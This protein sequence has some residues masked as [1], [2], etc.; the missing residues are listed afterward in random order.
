MIGGLMKT[1]SRFA[2]AAAAGLFAG[3][4]ALSPANAADLGGDCCADLEERVAELEATTVRKGNRK[5]SLNLSGHVNK[6]IM[7]WDD[8]INNDVY[9][10]DNDESETR[11]RLT[12]AAS[13]APGW[14]AGFIIE[15]EVESASSDTVDQRFDGRQRENDDGIVNNRRASFHVKNDQLGK[16]TIGYDS[17]ATDSIISLNLA[18]NPIADSDYEW[19]NSFLLARPQGSLGCTGAACRSG[20]TMNTIAPNLDTRRGDVV[21][22]D[23]PSLFGLVISA[24]WGEDDLA[25]V[26]VRFK[27]EWNSIRMVAGLGYLWDTDEGEGGPSSAIACPNP[28]VSGNPIVGNPTRNCVNERQDVEEFKGSASAMH[29]P[30]GLYAHAAFTHQQYGRSNSQAPLVAST[31]PSVVTGQQANDGT[32]WYLQAGVKRRLL[33]PNAGATTLYAEYQQF[34]DFG[35]GGSA[36]TL[37]GL[38]A[39]APTGCG[40]V[41]PAIVGTACSEVTDSQMSMWGV[42]IVQDI[43]PAAMKVYAALRLWDPTVRAANVP[44]AAPLADNGP[45]GTD[46][47]LEDFWAIAVGGKIEF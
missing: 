24:A 31:Y 47:S 17:P 6:M 29:V 37:L 8:E 45:A 27:K 18:D 39:N 26:A 36:D 14:S 3:G 21:R 38:N 15:I 20:V 4:I 1:T 43:D 13:I 41:A 2:I 46:V 5:V 44:N 12:G 22:Y 40:A 34:H 35:V 28:S 25:D 33:M 11:F 32:M 9:V 7:Y 10:V 30:T 16:L 42:G 19:G 23:S